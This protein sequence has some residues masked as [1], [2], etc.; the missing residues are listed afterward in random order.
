MICFKLAQY[1]VQVMIARVK[2]EK[3]QGFYTQ[4]DILFYSLHK[5]NNATR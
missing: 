3:L 5:L 1:V 2:S 4:L